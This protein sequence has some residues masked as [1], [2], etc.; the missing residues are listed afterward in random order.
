MESKPKYTE[1]DLNEHARIVEEI[2]DDRFPGA[3]QRKSLLRALN[4]H[5]G[6]LVS[7][8][9]IVREVYKQQHTDPGAVRKLVQHVKAGVAEYWSARTT[10][11]GWRC[12]VAPSDGGGY[13]LIWKHLSSGGRATLWFWKDHLDSGQRVIL[14][15]NELLFYGD[16][17]QNFVLR[18]LDL[19]EEGKSQKSLVAALYNQHP[20]IAKIRYLRRDDIRAMRV[21]MLMGEV[22]A[23]EVIGNWFAEEGIRVRN[24][25]SC[26]MDDD[27]IEYTSPIMLGNAR[28][29]KFIDA[30][31]RGAPHLKMRMVENTLGIE[32][33]L[34]REILDEIG[35]R[36]NVVTDDGKSRL[37]DDQDGDVYALVTRMPNPVGGKGSITMITSEYTRAI[38]KTA[39]LLT[40]D[41]AYETLI[42]DVWSPE[43]Q[44]ATFQ[45]ALIVRNG[46]QSSG[47]SGEAPQL[48][49]AQRY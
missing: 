26:R 32:L 17:A 1:E 20:E 42:Q 12:E 23:R 43:S 8:D 14:I 24:R 36:F 39:R 44:P 18:F 25:L 49:W 28:I 31:F 7:V 27:E 45:L 48:V 5:K 35:N 41:Q 11:G 29:N 19:N 46:S 21:Y 2:C 16:R 3:A 22:V 6:E 13:R 9:A 34:D 38:A 4:S 10:D 15:A 40:D 47:T 37:A 33:A 30:R